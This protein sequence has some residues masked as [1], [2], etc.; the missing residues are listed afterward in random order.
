M[1]RF[2][3]LRCAS[4]RFGALRCA[5]VRFGALRCA[6][7]RFGARSHE[8]EAEPVHIRGQLRRIV[9]VTCPHP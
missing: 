3:A 6:S 1:V 5:S 9:L 4:V 7:V 2:G 8:I